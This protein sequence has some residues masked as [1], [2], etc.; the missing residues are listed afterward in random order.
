MISQSRPNLMVYVDFTP[1]SK[2]NITL[3]SEKY[4]SLSYVL[5]QPVI[6]AYYVELLTSFIIVQVYYMQ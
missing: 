1:H 3:Q 2:I 4:M 5:L 6:H